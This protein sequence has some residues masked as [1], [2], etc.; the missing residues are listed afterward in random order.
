MI[1]WLGKVCI[2][3]QLAT[4]FV[5]HKPPSSS[6]NKSSFMGSVLFAL[7]IKASAL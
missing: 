2:N 1:L 5:K 6:G 3:V 4:L 7:N